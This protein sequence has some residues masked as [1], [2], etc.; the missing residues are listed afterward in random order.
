ML[1]VSQSFFITTPNRWF[2]VELHTAW[3][4]L[5]F[6]PKKVYRKV[7]AALGEAYWSKEENLNLLGK[8][9]LKTLFPKK[10]HLTIAS[11]RLLGLSTNLIVYGKSPQANNKDIG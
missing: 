11:T 6:L 3:P 7:L 4:F 9:E 2:P 5:H 8:K 10:V 1:R